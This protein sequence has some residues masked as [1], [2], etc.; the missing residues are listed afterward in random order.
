MCSM[1][2]FARKGLWVTDKLSYSTQTRILISG[3][4][5]LTRKPVGTG[6]K[7]AQPKV[8]HGDAS[9]WQREPPEHSPCVYV[10]AALPPVWFLVTL[11]SSSRQGSSRGQWCGLGHRT[12]PQGLLLSEWQTVQTML[13]LIGT[14]ALPLGHPTQ[15]RKQCSP[16]SLWLGH[17]LDWIISMDMADRLQRTKATTDVN[18]TTFDTTVWLKPWE[19]VKQTKADF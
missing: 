18:D 7:V 1:S 9:C 10:V 6:T 17:H 12:G 2:R 4:S 14:V 3:S 16:S 19:I 11:N 15:L 5:T 8:L 13:H